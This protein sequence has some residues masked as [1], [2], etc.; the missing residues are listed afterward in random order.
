MY[1][2]RCYSQAVMQALRHSV[3]IISLLTVDLRRSRRILRHDLHSLRR[4]RAWPAQ[5]HNL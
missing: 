1:A 5:C 2:I 3:K 4:M